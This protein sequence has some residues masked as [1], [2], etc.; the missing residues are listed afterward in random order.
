MVAILCNELKKKKYLQESCIANTLGQF[1]LF[2]TSMVSSLPGSPWN[3]Q[4][5]LLLFKNTDFTDSASTGFQ[6]ILK[7]RLRRKPLNKIQICL[8]SDKN[9]RTFTCKSKWVLLLLAIHNC[10]KSTAD[11]KF[12]KQCSYMQ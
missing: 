3:G 8:K 11:S 6:E 1:S 5:V 10:H 9:I 4:A 2:V 7:W 12:R